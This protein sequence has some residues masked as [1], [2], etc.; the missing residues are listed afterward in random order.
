[1]REVARGNGS[2]RA[3]ARDDNLGS[4]HA[5]LIAPAAES[6]KHGRI[7]VSILDKGKV[8]NWWVIGVRHQFSFGLCAL[9]ELGFGVGP[10]SGL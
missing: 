4:I 9:D 2:D 10:L 3:C 6:A 1:L 8:G 5:F 7:G